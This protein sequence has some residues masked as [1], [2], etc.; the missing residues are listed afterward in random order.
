MA[1]NSCLR[2]SSAL[3]TSRDTAPER[4][5]DGVESARADDRLRV[6]ELFERGREEGIERTLA[7]ARVP[8]GSIEDVGPEDRTVTSEK[9]HQSSALVRLHDQSIVDAIT[10][11]LFAIHK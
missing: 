4:F 7:T 11:A 2:P 6:G 9:D 3:R 10:H 1:A 5:D 8:I